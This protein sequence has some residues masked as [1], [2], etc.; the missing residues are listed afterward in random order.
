MIVRAHWLFGILSCSVL[1][2]PGVCLSA[3]DS[4]YDALNHGV[5][6]ETIRLEITDPLAPSLWNHISIYRKITNSTST[7]Y[8]YENNSFTLSIKSS[9]GNDV[10]GNIPFF[11]GDGGYT[12]PD[13]S[14][15]VLEANSTSLVVSPRPM[16]LWP[17][18]LDSD[19]KSIGSVA[20]D[21]P[22]D[23]VSGLPIFDCSY[24]SMAEAEAAGAL[25][26]V[27]SEAKRVGASELFSEP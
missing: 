9:K 23:L 24:D 2:Y 15:I 22:L 25:F 26:M 1:F 21:D 13:R 19:R 10:E 3:N 18:E 5:Q 17:M 16:V 11:E 14:K 8:C 7:S 20:M 4:E 12:P 27:T 6:L